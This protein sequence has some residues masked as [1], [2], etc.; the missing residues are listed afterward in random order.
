MIADGVLAIAADW[1][2]R[3]E[4]LDA[5]GRAELRAWLAESLDHAVAFDRFRRLLGDPALFDAVAS[6]PAL[7]PT[8]AP[9]RARWRGRGVGTRLR[10]RLAIAA[11][12]V[13]VIVAVPLGWRAVAPGPVDRRDYASAIAQ[14]RAVM[15][16]DGSAMTL[17]AASRITIA[18]G[19][20]GRDLSL[21]TG[22]AR[23]DVRHDGTRPFRV[24]T[25]DATMTALGT[26]FSAERLPGGSE[27]RVFRGRVRLDVPGSEP[28]VVEA[29]R[30]AS[31][32]DGG[33]LLHRLGDADRMS[34]RGAWIDG[35]AIPLATAVARLQRYS[36]TPIRLADPMLGRLSVSGRFPLDAPDRS[37][38]LI[39][40][41][42][43]LSVDRRSGALCLTSARYPRCAVR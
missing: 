42:F 37:V 10:R 41:L 35:D 11:A 16:P 3:G 43:D 19:S 32:R 23:F 1:A 30:Y 4:T 34:W 28:V 5:P 31:V 7:P 33:I 40:S 13:L 38:A 25:G 36:A 14:R 8:A 15:L 26:N 39:A 18:F 21:A 22:A 17:D 27:L 20:G 2:D 24:D 12:A 9:R 29:G 6:E